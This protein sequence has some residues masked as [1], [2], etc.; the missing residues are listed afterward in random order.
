MGVG[1]EKETWHEDM[2][3]EVVPFSNWE[4]GRASEGLK[5]S[6]TETGEEADGI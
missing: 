3:N 2:C 4:A 1:R 6:Q 5:G